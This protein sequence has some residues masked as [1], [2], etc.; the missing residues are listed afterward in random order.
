MS[1]AGKF[2]VGD[3]ALRWRVEWRGGKARPLGVQAVRVVEVAGDLVVWENGLKDRAGNLF[4]HVCKAAELIP[5]SWLEIL[6]AVPA[7]NPAQTHCALA[8]DAALES[9]AAAV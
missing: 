8:A 7:E 5:L 3:V 2:K 6:A 1:N 9:G 4:R